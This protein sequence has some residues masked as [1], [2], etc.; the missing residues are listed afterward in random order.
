M[1]RPE[2]SLFAIARL[3]GAAL[4]LTFLGV[5]AAAAAEMSWDDCPSEI[6]SVS[7]AIMDCGWLDTDEQL[8][9]ESVR[10]R[11]VILRARPGKP[12]PA[13]IV[14]V[15]GGPGDSAGLGHEGVARWRR[16]QQQAGWPHDIVLF[17]PRGT[18]ES[19]PRPRCVVEVEPPMRA[20]WHEPSA[21]ELSREAQRAMHCRQRLGDA[22]TVA[23]GPNAQLRD[24]R[25]LIDT[26]GV[27]RVHL[28]AVSY[29]TRI[30]RLFESRNP[31][32]VASMTLDSIVPFAEDELLA[33]P[34]QLRAAIDQ[35]VAFCNRHA[36]RC[37]TRSPRRAIAALLRR[38]ESSPPTVASGPGFW[39]PPD[40][41]VTP[42]RLLLM[43][44]LASYEPQ[45]AADTVTRVERAVQGDSQALKPMAKRLR[46][47]ARNPDH[48][49]A[50]FWSTRCALRGAPEPLTA[51][52][53]TL[54]QTPLV[55]PYI[56]DARQESGCPRWPTPAV[57]PPAAGSPAAPTLLVN[58]RADTAT[59][60]AW[61]R[62]FAADHPQVWHVEIPGAGHTPT[63][64][65]TCAQRTVAEFLRRPMAMPALACSQTEAL[66][67]GR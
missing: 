12:D 22:T 5:R 25:T 56:R 26:L 1:N 16:W 19:R 20:P 31:D 52:S 10:L 53:R 2:I 18:G 13:P 61:A 59:P 46:V 14:H 35:L 36:D 17:D 27:E 8:A 30:A 67:S 54:E 23:L 64:S 60:V 42:Y 41:Q 29:G 43:L 62:D 3:V 9:G 15:P 34:L 48:S 40:M 45:H 47:Q 24:L 50:V 55:A 44:L 57:E 7:A 32:R 38:Y 66:Q 63:L 39:A 4:L 28:W 51:W 58:G 11:V 21:D 49:A 33:L 65:D 6:G 37:A